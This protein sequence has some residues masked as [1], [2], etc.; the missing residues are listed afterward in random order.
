[1]SRLFRCLLARHPD[2]TFSGHFHN[3]LGLATANSLAALDA[4][5]DEVQVTF[6]G[7]GE[8]CGNAAMEEIVASLELSPAYR[9]R[10][11]SR[12]NLRAAVQTC[13][14]IYMIHGLQPHEKKP[15]IG[16]HAFTTCAGIHQ[17]GILKAPHVYEM[18]DPASI[19][20]RRAF[21]VNRLSSAKVRLE[22]SDAA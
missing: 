12:V 16:Q 5:I 8:R 13:D 20:R 15:L 2:I 4:G 17:D 11:R 19:G 22:S 10:Y 21:H 18:L 14:S 3:D 9:S 7:V 6:G 1:V